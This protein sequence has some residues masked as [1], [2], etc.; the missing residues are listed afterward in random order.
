M[1]ELTG[2]R[3]IVLV[4]SRATMSVMG[5]EEEKNNIITVA[6]HM[7]V[8]MNPQLYTVAIGKTR[9]SCKIMQKSKSFVVNFVPFELKEQALYCGTHSGAHVDKFR[10]SKLTMEEAEKIDCCRIKEAAGF[11][12]CEVVNEVDAGDHFIFIGKVVNSVS[13]EV[14]K[15]LFQGDTTDFTTTKN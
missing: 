11:M 10:E 12:E 6:W 14:A 5:K 7:P 3:Q 2:P 15:R 8:S 4:S 1:S 13:K 9:Y